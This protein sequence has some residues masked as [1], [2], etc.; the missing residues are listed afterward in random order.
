MARTRTS[1]DLEL[2]V[3]LD[4]ESPQPL[5]RQLEQAL[6]EA[7]RDGRLP[8]ATGLP[9]SRALATQLG[10]SRGI[11]VE[12]Y[13]QLVA[14][15]YLASRPGGATRVA[16]SAVAAP[17]H[18]PDPR[19]RPCAEFDFRPGRPDVSEFPRAVWLRS[20]RRG[21]AADAPSDRLDLPRRPRRSRSCGS[22]SPRTST[23]PA[24]RPPTR[25]TSSSAR[26]F[27]QGLAL[28]G[29]GDAGARRAR[30]AVEDPSDPEYRATLARGRPRH[31]GGPRR[32]ARPARRPA[33]AAR[34]RRR[35]RHRRPP[36]PDGRPSC[37]PIAA[38]PSRTGPARAGALIIEDDYDAE[39][40]YDRE[41]IGAIQ[42]L[43][44]DHVVYAGSASKVLA[45]GPAARLAAVAAAR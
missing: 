43:C 7:I 8:A 17:V 33:G 30:V 44:R 15:G 11:V 40:R 21:P 6:R 24:A 4:R 12:A 18:R 39:F 14:E 19:A 22:P 5:H 28:V 27:A 31:R 2:L 41:P 34:R 20:L 42:G 32:R 38:R 45:P 16:R 25:P 36:V 37:R 1:S 35:R 26:G 9:S 10:V 29:A 13:E 3:P 23:A